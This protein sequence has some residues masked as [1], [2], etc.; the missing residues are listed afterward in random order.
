METYVVTRSHQMGRVFLGLAMSL[1]TAFIGVYTGQFVPPAVVGLLAI[2]ELVMIFV[3]IMMQ[4][5]RSI[6]MPF[7]LTFTFISGITLYP[8][9]AR[10]AML[11]GPEALLKGIG[12]S[13][14]AF[15][16]AAA[17][18]SR[19]S[20]DFSWL[21][22]FLLIGLISIVLM[23]LVSIFLPFSTTMG[24]VYSILGIM[25]FVGYVLFDVNRMAR[26]GVS[27]SMVPWMVL[28]LYLDF[29]NLMLFV[30]ELMGFLGSS[31]R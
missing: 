14:V 25:V 21:G 20:F 4:R 2:A 19:T 31:R 13:T 27:E 23:G 15:L 22:G 10:Y 9:L 1:V 17:V 28:S 12:V 3:G 5:R 7:V 29:I 26:M 24:L 18:A 11:L 6:G 8:V 16:V 30:L